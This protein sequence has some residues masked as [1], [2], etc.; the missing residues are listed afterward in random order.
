MSVEQLTLKQIRAFAAVYRA[1][2]LSAA[3]RD[4]HVTQSAVSVL[5]RQIETVLGAQLFDRTTRSLVP[6]SAG[7]HAIGI[8]ERILNDIKALDHSINDLQH[9]ERGTVRLTATP[10]TGMAL[11]PETVRRFG[12]DFPAVSLLVDDCAPN[13]FLSNIREEKVEF[14]VGAPPR[15]TGEFTSRFIHEDQLCLICPNAHRLA[16]KTEVTWSDL[17]NEPL[18][19]SRR[20]YGVRDL[21]EA[22]LQRAGVQ[23]VLAAE[24]GFLSTATWLA[25]SGIGVGILPEKLARLFFTEKIVVR[26]LNAPRILR[27]TAVVVKKGRS[28]SASSE[29]FVQML[30]EDLKDR[31][32]DGK[33]ELQ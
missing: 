17:D 11:L 23:P 15:E 28:L 22:T 26:R 6:T 3:A 1:G 29:R 33:W 10:A 30:E 20:D 31:E 25:A 21:V 5:I 32:R 8:A 19:L 24:V 4:L 13:Q 14:G 27:P 7:E 18:I 16:G 2:Q 12:Q 9:L